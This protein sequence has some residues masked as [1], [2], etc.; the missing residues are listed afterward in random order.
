MTRRLIVKGDLEETSEDNQ[1]FIS[2][3][4]ELIKDDS[5]G[6]FYITLTDNFSCEIYNSKCITFFNELTKWVSNLKSINDDNLL[7][8]LKENF[9]DEHVVSYVKEAIECINNKEIPTHLEDAKI[10]L[11]LQDI[12]N[13]IKYEDSNIIKT[14]TFTADKD[15]NIG[16]DLDDYSLTI[17]VLRSS[18]NIDENKIQEMLERFAKGSGIFTVTS[19]MDFATRERLDINDIFDDLRFEVSSFGDGYAFDEI[20][21]YLDKVIISDRFEIKYLDVDYLRNR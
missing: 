5:K 21:D 1:T 10:Y 17:K 3:V 9:K 7:R 14:Y 18:E 19:A 16:N 6:Y 15:L 8:D 2:K 4:V 12:E 20:C 11:L 13:M